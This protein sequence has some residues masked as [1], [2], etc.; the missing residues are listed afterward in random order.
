[1]LGLSA[2]ALGN[3]LPLIPCS[4][5]DPGCT[6]HRQLSS[7]GGLTDAIVAG[8]A[9]SVLAFTT[10]APLWQRLSVLSGWRVAKF[11]LMLARVACPFLSRLGGLVVHR[12]GP[13]ARPTDPGDQL[14]GLGGGTRSCLVPC[15]RKPR[16][17]VQ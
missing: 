16:L 1:M 7:P 8:A 15:A 2:L 13:R 17:L 11:V 3:S 5:A 12:G 14:R 10:P 9:L 6:V 4:L